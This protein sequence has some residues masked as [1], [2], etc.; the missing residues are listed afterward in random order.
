MCALLAVLAGV[1]PVDLATTVW[2]GAWG[3]PDAAATTLSKTT[4]LLL[5]GL[6][7][8]LAYQTNLLNIG[9]EG[10]LTLGALA[11]SAF[12]VAAAPC[13]ALC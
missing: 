9:C 5:T 6:A 11:S 10:Q 12:A 1:A 3:S 4:P 2:T 8:S 13:P 7:V